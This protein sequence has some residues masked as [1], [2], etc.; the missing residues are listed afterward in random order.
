L[1][2][3]GP[4]DTPEDA[5]MLRRLVSEHGLHDR[6][7]LDIGYLDRDKYAAYV[8]G[9]AAVAYLPFDEDSLGYVAMEAATAAKPLITMHDSGGILG[10]AV[11]GQTGWVA[12]PQRPLDECL[13][14]AL[15][16]ERTS[17]SLG[18]A[19]HELWT[20]MDVSWD[21]TLDRLLP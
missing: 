8:N 4:A 17:V 6:V 3:A 12:G 11:D 7:V 13:S 14:L 20:S 16:D 15:Q 10:L 1:V 5:A 19:A 2:V 21:T 18:R 9:A